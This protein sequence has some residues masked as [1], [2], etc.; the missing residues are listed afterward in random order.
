MKNLLV[1]AVIVLAGFFAY[2]YFQTPLTEEEQKLNELKDE[3]KEAV[4]LTKQ[5][6]RSA[7]VGG[8]DSTSSFETGVERAKEIKDKLDEFI[9]EI[10]DEKVLGKAQELADRITEFIEENS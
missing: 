8:I 7:A 1:L 5:A 9:E 4:S 2:N 10:E 6:G 3:F